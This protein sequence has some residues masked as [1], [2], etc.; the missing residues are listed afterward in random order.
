MLYLDFQKFWHVEGNGHYHNRNNVKPRF[1]AV[2]AEEWVTQAQ[3]SL[4]GNGHRHENGARHCDVGERVK[5]VGEHVGEDVG[6]CIEAPKI[7][8]NSVEFS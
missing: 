6:F 8:E 5:K 2:W 3:V 4:Y 1:S 7:R